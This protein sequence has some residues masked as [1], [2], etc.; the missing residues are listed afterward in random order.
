MAASASKDFNHGNEV[1]VVLFSNCEKSLF[2]RE[3][4][5]NFDANFFKVK[6][7][8]IR[9]RINL[10]PY[11]AWSSSENGQTYF[12]ELANNPLIRTLT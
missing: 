1:R 12:S 10:I 8:K 4:R 7:P 2:S 9:K 3:L 6:I 5:S 11:L